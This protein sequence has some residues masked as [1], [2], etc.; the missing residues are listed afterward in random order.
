M[1]DS[2]RLWGEMQNDG[3]NIMVS[4]VS[5]DIERSMNKFCLAE[6]AAERADDESNFDH[7]VYVN[8]SNLF[9]S[10]EL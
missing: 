4:D 6:F 3:D 2:K 8:W 1:E 9:E 7:I 5:A 10:V